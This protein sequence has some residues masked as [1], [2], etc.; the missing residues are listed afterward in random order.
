MHSCVCD[1]IRQTEGIVVPNCCNLQSFCV[2]H[3]WQPCSQALAQLPV[4][5]STVKC[6]ASNG[7]LGEGLGTRL[8]Q[9][10]MSTIIILSMPIHAPTNVEQQN[11]LTFSDS[12]LS[13]CK[14]KLRTSVNDLQ[15]KKSC[16]HEYSFLLRTRPLGLMYKC[17]SHELYDLVSFPDHEQDPYRTPLRVDQKIL[18][19]RK[20]PM[21]SGLQW[22]PT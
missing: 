20:E 21:L 15:K 19:I 6:T 16:S 3:Q 7:K 22:N 2:D 8:H 14:H 5:C 1:D 9:W 12:Q 17:Y 11:L 4:T 18:S 10:H 13:F